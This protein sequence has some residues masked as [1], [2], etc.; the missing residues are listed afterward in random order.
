MIENIF[1]NHS[2]DD[3]KPG[4]IVW[5]D[6]DVRSARDFAGA[7]VV[8]NLERHYPSEPKIGDLAKTFFTLDCVVP[9]NNIGYAQNQQV[10]RLFARKEGIKVYD[11][12]SGIGSHVMIEQGL[13]LP[14]G[15]VVGTD[16]H[17]NIMG[18]IGCFGQGMGDQDIAFTFKAGKTWF[19]VPHSVKITVKGNT[20]QKTH[21]KDLTLALVKHFTS[22]G[23]L[24][25]SAEFYGDPIEKM[26]LAGRITLSSMV[27]EMGGIIGFIPPNNEVI[28][29][30]KARAK[31]DFEPVFADEDASY[32][33]EVEIDVDGLKPQIACPY[34]PDNVKNVE[35]VVGTRIDSVVIGS[36]TNGRYEDIELVAKILK[37]K[38][39]A[40]HVMM[41]VIP[42]TKEIYG[43]ML[44]NDLLEIFYDAGVIV[45]NPGCAGCASGQIGMTGES[46]VQISTGNRNFAGKQGKGDN[47]LASPAT[48]TVS[49][50]AGE[51]KSP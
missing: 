16:S 20:D 21:S 44:K 19:E 13:A 32:L 27:T 4:E 10:I 45:S 51:I 46:E 22:S 5:M 35:E 12:D 17:L 50:I 33:K 41:K 3:I 43:Q 11:V 6:I 8:N 36:C 15:T 14:G 31:S 1:Q 37:G 39:V 29:F 42:A 38:K 24:G 7:N 26:S 28:D 9:A 47:Y 2:S 34:S 23:L 30:C 18:S 40:E 25:L 49:A 48:A